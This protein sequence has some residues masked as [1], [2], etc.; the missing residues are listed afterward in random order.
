MSGKAFGVLVS[1]GIFIGIVIMFFAVAITSQ[2]KAINLE[3][4]I[5]ESSSAINVQ[6]KRRADL[7]INLVDTVQAYDNHEK[8]TMVLLTE[9]RSKASEGLIGE[10]QIVIT[11]VTEAYPELK[12]IQNYQTLMNELATTENMIAEHRNNFNIQVRA[13]NKHVR[14]FPN[15]L[16]LDMLG[17]EKISADYLEY[18][19]S[20]DAPTNLFNKGD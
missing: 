19:T 3:E 12:S 15:R 10:A 18:E 1:V 9:A 4:Q 5:N 11:A 14:K 17:Y 6:E 20:P 8:E 7:I 13:Y 16:L 2:N